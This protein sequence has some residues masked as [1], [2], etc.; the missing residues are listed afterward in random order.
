MTVVSDPARRLDAGQTLT[1]DE[2]RQ[3][4]AA[5]RRGDAGPESAPAGTPPPTPPPVLWRDLAACRRRPD[6]EWTPADDTGPDPRCRDIC[7]ACPVRVEC[8]DDAV[9]DPGIVGVRGGH[10]FRFVANTGRERA[11]RIHKPL[12]ANPRTRRRRTASGPRMTAEQAADALAELNQ[13]AGR[14][15]TIEPEL[16]RRRVADRDGYPTSSGIHG[17]GGGTR[18]YGDPV[19]ELAARRIDRPGADPVAAAHDTLLALVR[20]ARAALEQAE[21]AARR[22]RR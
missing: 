1:R 17:R 4:T 16:R 22:I 15:L 3:I 19:G 9:A 5:A 8:F 10:W 18:G 12:S 14:L 6:I 20:D 11:R 13:L 21:S 2:W 7:G